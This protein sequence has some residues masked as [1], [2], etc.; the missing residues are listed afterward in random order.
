[1]TSDVTRG[2]LARAVLEGLA[3]EARTSLEPLLAFAGLDTIPSITAIGGGAKND[4]LLRIKASV[5]NTPIRVL[6]VEE[7]TALGAAMLGGLAAAVYRDVDDAVASIRSQSHVVEPMQ[8]TVAV[9]D[10]YY[11]DVYRDLYNTLRPL[12]HRIHAL[13]VGETEAESPG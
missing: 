1:M 3:F 10:A 4:L 9:Y 5:I 8:D 12:N 13:A 7:G 11:R 2:T 6:D